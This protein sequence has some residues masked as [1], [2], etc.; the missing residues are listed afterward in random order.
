MFNLNSFK[1]ADGCVAI[2]NYTIFVAQL[3]RIGNSILFKSDRYHDMYVIDDP[4]YCEWT[5][6][7]DFTFDEAFDL[8]PSDQQAIVLF[9]LN[10]V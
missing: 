5:G 10:K 8:L 4:K 3:V 6:M 1:A 2:T 9:S 7:R